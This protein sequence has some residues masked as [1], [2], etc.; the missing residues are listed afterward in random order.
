M[1]EIHMSSLAWAASWRLCHRGLAKGPSAG[2]AGQSGD[3][4]PALRDTAAWHERATSVRLSLQTFGFLFA[5]SLGFFPAS[6]SLI[7]TATC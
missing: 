7:T 2:P 4:R 5:W 1:G 3:R 6:L